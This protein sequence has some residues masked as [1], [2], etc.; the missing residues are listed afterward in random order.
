[1]GDEDE[2]RELIGRMSG[3]QRQGFHVTPAALRIV[4]A[5]LQFYLAG[6]TWLPKSHPDPRE[7]PPRT[8]PEPYTGPLPT[9]GNCRGHG[10]TGF[11]VDCLGPHCHARR[12]FTFEDVGAADDEVFVDIPKRRRF[13]CSRCGSRKVT[14]TADWPTQEEKRRGS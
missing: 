2:V 9:V 8:K 13:R 5:A 10:M 4:L 7:H 14:V 6:R 12:R 1:M 3:A 11:F